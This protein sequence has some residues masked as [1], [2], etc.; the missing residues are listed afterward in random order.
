VTARARPAAADGARRCERFDAAWLASRLRVL[1]GPLAGVPFCV[2]FSGGVDSTALLLAL[3]RLRRRHRFGLRAL[4]VN[5][6]LQPG[7]A[8]GRGGR[9]RARPGGWRRRS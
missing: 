6:Q 3:A 4:H 8:L 1:A 7:A 9:R 5:H 2:A